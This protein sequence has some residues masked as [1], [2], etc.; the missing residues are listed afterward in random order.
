MI[1]PITFKNVP[2]KV[3]GSVKYKGDLILTPGVIYY[4]PHTDVANK[5][6]LVIAIILF[7]VL[8]PLLAA[9]SIWVLVVF[10]SLF[11]LL[12]VVAGFFSP[13][14]IV[15]MVSSAIKKAWELNKEAQETHH[16]TPEPNDEQ[17]QPET[18]GLSPLINPYPIILYPTLWYSLILDS[19]FLA[20]K[21]N[22]SLSR[23][24]IPTPT[25]IL[26]SDIRDISLSFT[27]LLLIKTEF[28]ME[29]KFYLGILRKDMLKKF[30]IEGGYF[31]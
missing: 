2:Y 21:E 17:Q 28:D 14:L 5:R 4:F 24:S 18:V 12:F 30:L 16:H 7:I 10:G 11:I 9:I 22:K 25:R 26:K 29:N 15:E 27:G 3:A 31:S 23:H 6:F 8:S 19:A 1:L 13:D 20:L